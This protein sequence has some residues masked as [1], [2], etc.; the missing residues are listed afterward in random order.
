M[1]TKFFLAALLAL[2]VIGLPNF[3]LAGMPEAVDYLKNQTPDAW[4]TQALIAA[5]ETNVSVSHLKSVAEGGFN[6]TNDYAKVILALAAAGE[7]PTTFG[8]IDYVAKLKTYY[9]GTQMGDATLLN[10]DIWS[11]LALASIKKTGS[12]EAIAAKNFLLSHQNADGGWGYAVGGSSGSNDTAAAIM[13]LIEAGV[14]ANNSAI[15]KAAV[16]LHTLQNAD[17]GFMNDPAW[18][19][20]SDSGSDGWVISAIYKIGQDPVS[21]A[22]VKTGHNPLTHMRSLQDSA[23]GG[24]WWV[25][26]AGNP[27]FNN[28]AMTAYAVIAL[29]GKSFP[30]GYYEIPPA[31]RLSVNKSALNSG[32]TVVI[33]VE[34]FDDQNWLP[35]AG[36]V[37]QG[38]A[39]N[40]TTNDSGQASAAPAAGDYNLSAVKEGFTASQPVK[41]SVLAPAAPSPAPASGGSVIFVAPTYCQSAEYDV[42]QNTCV[43]SWQYR[44]VLTITPA[45]CILTAEQESQRKKACVTPRIEADDA[46]SVITNEENNENDEIKPEV[47]GIKIIASPAERLAEA[48]AEANDII[49]GRTKD[50]VGVGTAS[51]VKLGAGER[52]GALNSYKSAFGKAPKTQAEWEDVIRISNNQLPLATNPAAEKKA[53]IEFKKVYQ[54]EADMKNY[55]DQTAI[56]LISYG[57]RPDKRDLDSERAGIR[58]FTEIYKYLPVSALDWDTVRAMAYS[59]VEI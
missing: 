26:P 51:T 32:E 19:T 55:N 50:F 8:K 11:I 25:D 16:F 18:G 17:G 42:W 45:N 59:G 37:I 5:G 46:P 24:F 12:A 27:A 53:K 20:D 39:Q 38:L 36:A 35:L 34:Y 13:A 52:A 58:V 4:I 15:T 48:A 9:D 47:L 40:Y 49:S 1:K 31:T 3:A 56:N 29:A 14:E 57:L 7:N 41:I 22:W 43:D 6:P 2:V 30:V 54:R 44:N 10:D 33:T 23:D 21:D 28:K